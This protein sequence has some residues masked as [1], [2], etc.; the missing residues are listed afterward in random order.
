MPDLVRAVVEVPL[1]VMLPAKVFVPVFMPVS[2]RVLVPE[3]AVVNARFALMVMPLADADA[4]LSIVPPPVAPA[5]SMARLVKVRAMVAPVP[6][7][8]MPAELPEPSLMLPLPAVS[9]RELTETVPF[10]APRAPVKL[11]VELSRYVV[12]V[13]ETVRAPAPVI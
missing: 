6:H 5:S 7:W 12:A 1:L 10:C 8:K 4:E 2:V 13:L 11:L 3:L 9:V